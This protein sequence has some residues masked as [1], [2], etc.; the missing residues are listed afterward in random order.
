MELK[1][2]KN[3]Q[4]AVLPV[5]SLFCLKNAQTCK[6]KL[7]INEYVC[8]RV[9]GKYSLVNLINVNLHVDLDLWKFSYF[10]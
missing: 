7:L 5:L 10:D 9:R 6:K 2:K 3:F 4:K 8:M 1:I